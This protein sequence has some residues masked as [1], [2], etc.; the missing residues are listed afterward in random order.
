MDH[1]R[2]FNIYKSVIEGSSCVAC[3]IR[4]I[5]DKPLPPPAPPPPVPPPPPG[6]GSPPPIGPGSGDPPTGGTPNPPSN[7]PPK[8]PDK[9]GRSCE[10]N[11]C[12]PCEPPVGSLMCRVDLVP[13]ST[14]QYP[15]KG[16]H[17]K[18]YM[19][20]QSP[21]P[22]CQCFL[23]PLPATDGASPYPGEIP[24]KSVGGGGPK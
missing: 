14:P 4:L 18:H 24:V 13:P 23:I 9:P 15:F 17:T 3:G 12:K 20:G 2:A 10:W 1:S 7:D 11:D 21:A 8:P 19:V 22:K 6:E 5:T 16:T